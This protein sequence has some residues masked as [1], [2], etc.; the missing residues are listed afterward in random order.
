M[1]ALSTA[2]FEA[3]PVA[4]VLPLPLFDNGSGGELERI[5]KELARELH[6]QLAQS[7]YS[8]LMQTTVFAREQQGRPDVLA[9]HDF[10]QTSLR[11]VLNNLRQL[12]A[13][14]RGQPSLANDFLP[15]MRE[16]LMRFE[17]RTRVKV[18]LWISRSWPATLP[19]ETCI[20][21]FRI[22]Q[23]ASNNAYKH[24]GASKVHV[25]L[26][27]RPDGRLA[28]SI[29]DNGRGI[30]CQDD[31]K[32]VGMGIVG[33]RERAS[34]MGGVLT[35]RNRRLGGTTV[36]ASIPKEVLSWSYKKLPPAS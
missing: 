20:H 5:K 10:M 4:A 21:V 34:L 14:L 8:M 32:P 18:N 29:R 33:M 17:Q 35:I 2:A 31:L 22:V 24:G 30:S 11:E 27:A 28:I 3:P 25:V 19:P 15:A 1:S 36:T 13:E 9:Q 26:K 7:L 6:D 12:L 16:S 23:E